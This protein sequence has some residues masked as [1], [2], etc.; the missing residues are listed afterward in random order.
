MGGKKGTERTERDKKGREV[1]VRGHGCPRFSEPPYVLVN[2]SVSVEP[3]RYQ[4]TLRRLAGGG[5]GDTHDIFC[6]YLA[7]GRSRVAVF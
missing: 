4:V 7:R 5:E 1:E 6:E 3:C 2:L